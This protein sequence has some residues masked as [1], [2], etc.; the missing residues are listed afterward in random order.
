MTGISL[1]NPV[2]IVAMSLIASMVFL[3]AAA[4]LG[5]DKGVLRSMSTPEYAR[6]LITYL[7]AVMTIGT[8]VIL[9]LSTL[10]TPAQ[11]AA[12]S[13]SAQTV[14]LQGGPPQGGAQPASPL[15]AAQQTDP[16]KDQFERG[17][18]ILSLLLGVFGT[19]VGYY[20][21]SSNTASTELR[22]S[23]PRVTPIGGDTA[24]AILVQ[25]T[26]G[27]GSAPYLF[28]IAVGDKAAE[29]IEPVAEDGWI[30]REV[31]LSGATTGP[32]VI[33]VVAQDASGKKI[34][35]RAVTLLGGRVDPT[36]AV[37]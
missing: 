12:Q 17:K 37:A 7:F 19:I 34:E 33:R 6:G 4:V 16:V 27:G 5:W 35:R 13:G 21:G 32:V 11:P 15:A 1:Y 20:F 26:V 31:P 14:V 30:V 10:V 29:P 28:G 2:V 8:A 22:V 36:P 24:K 23:Q 3:V 9:V 25:C 18:E